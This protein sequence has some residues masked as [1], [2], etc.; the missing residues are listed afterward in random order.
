MKQFKLK[1][2]LA[3]TLLTSTSIASAQIQIGNVYWKQTVLPNPTS[4]SFQ[5]EY[6]FFG[7]QYV[8]PQGWVELYIT[9]DR[10]TIRKLS[11][12]T[13]NVG[14]GTGVGALCKG[15]KT[16]HT[17]SSYNMDYNTKQYLDGL[18]EPTSFDL[19]AKYNYH[20][21]FSLNSATLGTQKQADWAFTGGSMSPTTTHSNGTV[22]VQYKIQTAC[23][24]NGVLPKV[25]VYLTDANYN[26][27]VN[28][29]T[30][31]VTGTYGGIYNFGLNFSAIGGLPAGQYH[32]AL[33]ADATSIVPE[34]N[35]N[36]NVGTFPLTI[37]SSTSA[38]TPFADAEAAFTQAKR[39]MPV[40]QYIDTSP[41]GLEGMPKLTESGLAVEQGMIQ[42]GVKVLEKESLPNVALDNESMT[43]D[44]K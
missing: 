1:T 39:E 8:R 14:C 10:N 30:L 21:A 27:L 24:G 37:T 40:V 33:V 20:T 42:G 41:V 15:S 6:S 43:L 17:I 44:N 34:S 19:Y 25:A 2:F 35:E 23:A 26:V 32:I 16:Y 29:G 11:N 36:N 12:G 38:I 9:Q 4:S 28:Y 13:A 3:A 31:N 22:S 7:S 5:V 18:C